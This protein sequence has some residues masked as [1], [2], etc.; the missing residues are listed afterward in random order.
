MAKKSLN[1]AVLG[2]GHLGKWHWE[3]LVTLSHSFNIVPYAIVDSSEKARSK[4]LGLKPKPRVVSHLDEVVGDLHAAIIATPTVTHFAMIKKLLAHG[5]HIFCE[6]PM[7]ATYCEALELKALFQAKNLVFQVGHSERFH[8][9]WEYKEQFQEIFQGPCLIKI[10]RLGAFKNR[11]VDVDVVSDLMVHDLDILYFLLGEYPD[12]ISSQGFKV[13]TDHFDSVNAVLRYKFGKVAILT[14]SRT[15][16]EEV[17]TFQITNANGSVHIDLL[18]NSIKHIG[19]KGLVSEI[20][21]EKRDHLLLEQE[22]F[23]RA[24]LENRDVPVTLNDGLIAVKL[25]DEVLKGL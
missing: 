11:A 15:H 17:R 14:S 7:T 20:P 13:V 24:I 2:L 6:K 5:V 12:S 3:K 21:Y 10:D 16:F 23:Y 9:A 19:P 1:V 18:N 8:K 22:S 25:V 4:A